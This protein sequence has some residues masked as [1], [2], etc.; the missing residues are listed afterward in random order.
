MRIVCVSP[1][2]RATGCSLRCNPVAMRGQ[3]RREWGRCGHANLT[4]QGYVERDGVKIWYEVFGAGATPT[5]VLTPTWPIVDSRHWKA[6]VPFLARH[7]RV[8]TFDPRG[9]GRSDRPTDPADYATTAEFEGDLL[10]VM[11]AVEVGPGG[12]GRPVHAAPGARWPA[13]AR[14][15]ERVPGRRG[16]RAER[17]LARPPRPER[18]VHSFER[19]AG[20]RRGLGEVQPPLLAAATCRGFVEFFFRTVISE[21]HSTKQIEDA[22]GW[23][24]QTTP[25]VA[26][27]GRARAVVRRRPGRHRGDAARRAVPGAGHPRH[28]G[29]VPARR[30]GC[31]G[32][33]ELTGAREVVLE[34]AGH[35]A[36]TREPVVVNRLLHEFV[37]SLAPPAP[38]PPRAGPGRWTGPSGC[39]TCPRRSAWGTPSGTRRSSTR[40]ARQRPGVQVDWLAQHPVTE[41]L[42]RR[43]ERVHPASALPGVRSRTHIEAEAGEHDLHAFQAVRRMDEILVANF[44]VF[45]EVVRDASTYDLWVGDEAWELDYFLHENPELKRAAVRLADRLRRLAADAVRRPAEADADRR[46]QRRDGRADR[47]LPAAARPGRVRRQPGRHRRRPARARTCRAS[48]SGPRST[49]RSPATSR[50]FAPVDDDDAPGCGT[51]SAGRRTRRSCVATVGGSGVG[52]DLLRRVVDAFPAAA[53]ARCPG[54]AWSSWPARAST[55]RGCPAREGL[56]VHG[57]VDRLHRLLAA[58]D[59]AITHGGLTTTM[60]LTAHRRPFLYVPLRN[61]FEQNF[62]VRHRLDRYGAGRHLAWTR[63]DRRRTSWPPR[64]RRRSAGRSTTGRW[65]PTAPSGRRRCS[66]SCSDAARRA[67]LA[68]GGQRRHPAGAG[69]RASS[70]ASIVRGPRRLAAGQPGPGDRGVRVG[71]VE[72][73]R[74]VRRARRTD[75]QRVGLVEQRRRRRSPR[76]AAPGSAAGRPRCGAIS[77]DRQAALQHRDRPRRRGRRTRSAWCAYIAVHG[78]GEPGVRL[79][80]GRPAG[81]RRAPRRG[82]PASRAIQPRWARNH[83]S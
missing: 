60:T 1:R 29:P 32:S 2:L 47:P 55:R 15:P 82:R 5:V 72:P 64:S 8:V 56:E 77:A 23:A 67:H 62:H 30:S 36:H 10:A 11:D 40:C 83:D 51:S 3:A 58:C 38:A 70:G 73:G 6:Q 28:R 19:P 26:D 68:R 49:S 53:R 24:M 27:R 7:F 13:A 54:C 9:N 79:H 59:L 43:G 39:S 35:L 61:H 25:E 42:A 66:P 74:P 33:A 50:D 12:A 21:P 14:H 18:G 34:G 75:E 69:R 4:Q 71:A 45:A 63:T 76:P 16:D 52:G 48:A 22:V 80:R 81:R 31:C 65:R 37:A 17:A 57:Y 78:R 20:H 41:V 44:M 46:L